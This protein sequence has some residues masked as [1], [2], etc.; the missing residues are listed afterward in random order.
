MMFVTDTETELPIRH[1]LSWWYRLAQTKMAL[2][3][4]EL[5]KNTDSLTHAHL[6]G[7]LIIINAVAF[8]ILIDKEANA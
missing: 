3:R 7:T 2:V 5:E 6:P 8:N 4:T 1:P